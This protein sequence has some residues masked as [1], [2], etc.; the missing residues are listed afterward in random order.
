MALPRY[1]DLSPKEKAE[2][3]DVPS[4]DNVSYVS[5]ANYRALQKAGFK[6]DTVDGVD[7]IPFSG[8][9]A[10]DQDSIE[11]ATG[12]AAH[13]VALLIYNGPNHGTYKKAAQ[14][15]RCPRYSNTPEFMI[16]AFDSLRGW[17]F[18]HS[19]II[20]AS[21]F[22][23]PWW[24]PTHGG[25]VVLIC[26]VADSDYQG[27][28]SSRTVISKMEGPWTAYCSLEPEHMRFVEINDETGEL[29][30]SA[31][32]GGITMFEKGR[33]HS[34]VAL[35]AYL[36]DFEVKLA[37]AITETSVERGTKRALRKE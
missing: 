16:N 24:R 37:Q 1:S 4:C 34:V 7:P 11:R 30:V 8:V 6:L 26:S 31:L 2:I 19:T 35:G 18:P 23:E 12:V 10:F 29:N 27:Y 3:R 21:A 36:C 33:G 22:Y 20:V 17:K 25:R 32:V 13:N 14:S 9:D 5:V 15:E 28:K